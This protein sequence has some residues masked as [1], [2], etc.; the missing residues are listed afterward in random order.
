MLPSYPSMVHLL[1]GEGMGS[2]VL[3]ADVSSIGTGS[4][5]IP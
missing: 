4:L 1:T 5:L 2:G 3:A